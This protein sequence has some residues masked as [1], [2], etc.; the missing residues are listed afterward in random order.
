MAWRLSHN[1][2]ELKDLIFTSGPLKEQNKK[3]VGATQDID[4]RLDRSGAELRS[5]AQMQIA[6]LGMSPSY[7][8][9]SPFLLVM[10]QRT[11]PRPFLVIWV[12]NDELLRNFTQDSQSK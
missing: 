5:E 9:T 10:R 4:F 3:I 6:T 2:L 8:I 1:F 12:E 7:F 11:S